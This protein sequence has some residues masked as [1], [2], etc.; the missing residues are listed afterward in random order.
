MTA[1]LSTPILFLIGDFI[2]K[3]LES[4]HVLNV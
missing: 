1:L 3:I 4:A 2:V